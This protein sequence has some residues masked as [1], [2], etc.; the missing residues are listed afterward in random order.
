MGCTSAGR[1]SSAT[2][3][4]DVPGTTTAL[5]STEDNSSNSSSSNSNREALEV[6][7]EVPLYTKVPQRY[8]RGTTPKFWVVLASPHHY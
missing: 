2:V 8:H 1:E 3:G 7:E 5:P 4:W 6:A